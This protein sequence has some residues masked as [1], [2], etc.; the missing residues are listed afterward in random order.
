VYDQYSAIR[1][2]AN[3]AI[4]GNDSEELAKCVKVSFV[5]NTL[6]N[7]LDFLRIILILVYWLCRY[8]KE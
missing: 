5:I 6:N 2:A 4:F 1:N 8:M 3:S 7:Y